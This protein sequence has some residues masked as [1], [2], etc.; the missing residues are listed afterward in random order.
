[1]LLNCGVAGLAR[2][3]QWAAARS[4]RRPWSPRGLRCECLGRCSRRR[5]AG[6]LIEARVC[7]VCGT[8]WS[9]LDSQCGARP[10]SDPVPLCSRCTFNLSLQA[11]PHSVESLT[12][13][14]HVQVD[15]TNFQMRNAL[16][17][18]ACPKHA[19]PRDA[20]HTTGILRLHARIHPHARTYA[21]VHT[22]THTCMLAP[23]APPSAG[24]CRCTIAAL[25]KHSGSAR[26]HA[27]AHTY[28]RTHARV[29]THTL[30]VQISLYKAQQK[31][32][33]RCRKC[34]VKGTGR[35]SKR[36]RRKSPESEP[37]ADPVF[38]RRSENH[39]L[40]SDFSCHFAEAIPRPRE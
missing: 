6:G 34:A 36:A 37:C 20:H 8:G 23:G 19:W 9:K 13:L 26:T 11:V 38:L 29:R 40:R 18:E 27:H 21:R 25:G 2:T 4:E 3:R 33:E 35:C 1:M 30:S 7:V 16:W 12:R 5:A 14:G 31:S 15:R 28:S 24:C 39:S 17:G 10:R 32:A 22:H